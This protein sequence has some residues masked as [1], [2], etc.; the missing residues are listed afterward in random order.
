VIEQR[1]FAALGTKISAIIQSGAELPRWRPAV[2]ATDVTLGAFETV[3]EI[4]VALIIRII[5]Q[6][7]ASAGMAILYLGDASLAKPHAIDLDWRVGRYAATCAAWFLLFAFGAD[8]Q[9]Q[10]RISGIASNNRRR[11]EAAAFETGKAPG[12]KWLVIDKNRRTSKAAALD[13]NCP[14]SPA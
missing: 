6:Q 1:Y 4:L 8:Q 10:G 5:G 3:F 12:A 9:I 2:A 14:V 13:A 7:R 11:T